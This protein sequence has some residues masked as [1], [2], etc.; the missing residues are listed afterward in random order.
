[1]VAINT[2]LVKKTQLIAKML[3][4]FHVRLDIF[5]SFYATFTN[6]LIFTTRNILEI[7]SA[8]FWSNTRGTGPLASTTLILFWKKDG[9]LR[10]LATRKQWASYPISKLADCACAGNAGNFFPATDVKPRVSD[11][12]MH[13]DTRMTH[14]PW[15]MSGSLTRGGGKN[16][17]GITGTCA[18]RKFSNLVIDPCR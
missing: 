13:L 4:I 2:L 12:G 1:M 6:I 7:D 17:P 9:T 15:C 11:P 14:V 18:T 3:A 5:N 10:S 8:C 16:V